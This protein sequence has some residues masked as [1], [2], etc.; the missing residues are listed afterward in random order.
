MRCIYYLGG[1]D[2]VCFFV[3]SLEVGSVNHPET[4]GKLYRL[5]ILTSNDYLVG[6]TSKYTYV[7]F[8]VLTNNVEQL[9]LVFRDV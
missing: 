1:D 9:F 8:K 4:R 5:F 6:V 7:T 2:C 3:V